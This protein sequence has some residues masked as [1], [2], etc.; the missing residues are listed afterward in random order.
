MRKEK[1]AIVVAIL[2]TFL[3]IASLS[4]FA[5]AQPP[6]DHN[7]TV[8]DVC[9]YDPGNDRYQTYG[10]FYNETTGNWNYSSPDPDEDWTLLFHLDVDYGD[11]YWA[12]CINYTAPLWIGDTFNASIYPVEPTCK[13]NSIAYILNNWIID[14]DNCDNV[15]AG[16]SAVWYFWYID[17]PFCSGGEAKYNHTATPGDPNWE[18]NWIPNCTAHPLACTFIN[19]SIN[20]SVP[21]NISTTPGTGTFPKGAPVEL[22]ATVDYCLGEVGAEVTVVF[23]T[24]S[25]TFSE[26]GTN[27]YENGTVNGIAKATLTCDPSVDTAHVTAQVKD[28]KWLE[29]VDPTL[30]QDTQYQETLRIVNITDDA[31]FNFEA[32]E[33]DIGINKLVDGVKIE[34][35]THNQV[36]TYTLT[37]TNTGEV[38]LTDIM[39]VDTLP[40]DITWADDADPVEDSVTPEA[41]GTTTIV[42]K[43]NLTEPFI[44]EPFEPGDSFVIRFNA[45]INESAEYYEIYRNWAKVNATSE[46][47]PAGPKTSYADVY[48]EDPNKVP[49]LTPLG[50]AALIGLLSLV[51][52]LSIRKSVR[53]KKG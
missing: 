52:V 37:I 23:E 36:V 29:I 42:W 24:D 1:T 48:L 17:E 33:P 15:S 27:V 6:C 34:V 4:P 10:W 21:Y 31:N 18:S 9:C 39:V 16:Q 2:A 44:T 25:G 51:V 40:A 49:V 45:T 11:K 41:D 20:Q 28:M 26:S 8:D 43:N 7:V 46:W 14:C 5:S 53:K 47:G 35:V 22:N 12:Y 13:N 38:N 30:C 19:A 3:C 32:G 50:V